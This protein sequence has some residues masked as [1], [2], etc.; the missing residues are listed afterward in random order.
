MRKW[1]LL[2]GAVAVLSV[3][4]I[5]LTLLPATGQV[6]G[7]RFI[8]CEKD[9]KWDQETEIHNPP[10]GFSA[11]DGF[12]F[13][14]AEFDENG[15]RVGDLYGQGTIM[16]TIGDRD[17]V[18]Q[19]NVSLNLDGGRIEAQGAARFSNIT[20]DTHFSIIGGTGKFEGRTGHLT[21]RSRSCPGVAKP[22]NGDSLVVKFD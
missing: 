2:G 1:K 22:G 9:G 18:I 17:A 19:F 21:P 5:G 14:E 7:D 16:K 11:A 6:G 10:A 15:D 4:V 13:T 12:V 3:G 20:G 8:L